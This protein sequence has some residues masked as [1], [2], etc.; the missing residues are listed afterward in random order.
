MNTS[1]TYSSS[2][3]PVSTNSTENTQFSAGAAKTSPASQPKSKED[4]KDD[5]AE[6]LKEKLSDKAQQL[7]HEI[8]GLFHIPEPIR[9]HPVATILGGTGAFLLIGGAITVG[10]LESQRR[11]TFSYRFMKGLRQVSHALSM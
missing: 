8:K 2:S 10:I 4:K 5:K 3:S 1:T 6:D 7:G 9:N 11:Q